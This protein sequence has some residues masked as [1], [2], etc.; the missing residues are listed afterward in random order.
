MRT[1]A[2]WEYI[3]YGYP[4]ACK[5]YAQYITEV[6]KQYRSLLTGKS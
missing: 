2:P 1:K 5:K 6:G 4:E 3:R